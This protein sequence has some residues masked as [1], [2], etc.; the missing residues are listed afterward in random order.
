MST[1]KIKSDRNKI[2]Y[3]I[4]NNYGYISIFDQNLYICIEFD[5]KWRIIRSGYWILCGLIYKS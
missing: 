5:I 2:I 1:Q 3:I 4:K